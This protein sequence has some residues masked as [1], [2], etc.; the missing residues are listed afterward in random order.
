MPISLEIEDEKG[1]TVYRDAAFLKGTPTV[2]EFRTYLTTVPY[3]TWPDGKPVF[4][5]PRWFNIASIKITNIATGLP[6]VVEETDRILQFPFDKYTIHVV[7]TRKPR[8]R[9]T[10]NISGGRRSTTLRSRK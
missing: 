3:D 10:K 9:K 1:N 8:A 6:V 5:V 7:V 4:Y 2:A